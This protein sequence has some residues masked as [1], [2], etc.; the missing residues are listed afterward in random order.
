MS[1]SKNMECKEVK[2]GELLE[3]SFH[4]EVGMTLTTFEGELQLSVKVVELLFLEQNSGKNEG[5]FGGSVGEHQ[6]FYVL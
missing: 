2:R 5:Y 6:W 3:R 4:L 1:L